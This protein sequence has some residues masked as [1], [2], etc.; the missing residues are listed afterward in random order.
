MA[1][2]VEVGSKVIFRIT[3]RQPTTAVVVVGIISVHHPI[4]IGVEV[5]IG[6]QFVAMTA[7]Y[8]ATASVYITVVVGQGGPGQVI[9]HPV[10][11]FQTGNFDQTIVVVVDIDTVCIA[12]TIGVVTCATTTTASTTSSE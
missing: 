1:V 3:N 4:A 2:T 11:L 5:Q 7:V 9:T 8:R 10:Q 12:V 6:D